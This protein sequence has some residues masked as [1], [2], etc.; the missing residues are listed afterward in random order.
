MTSHAND[1]RNVLVRHD[2]T[3]VHVLGGNHVAGL[4]TTRH[5]AQQ[6]ELWFGRME[7]GASSPPHSHDTE[8]V[9][10]FLKGSGY[11]TVGGVEVGFRSG[12]TLILPAGEVHQLVA[13]TESEFF[14]AMPSG[15]TLRFSYGEVMDLPWRR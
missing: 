6:V 4:A 15:G 10:H 14:A 5:G 12:D 11:A 13:E 8:E 1:C 2:A 9:V 7:A 3:Q